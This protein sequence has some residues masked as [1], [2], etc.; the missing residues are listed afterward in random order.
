MVDLSFGGSAFPR[1]QEIREL[2][3]EKGDG[4]LPARF[5][6][7][8]RNEAF[9]RG[10]EYAH[11]TTDWGGYPANAQEAISTESIMPPGFVRPA[12]SEDTNHRL[13]RPTAPLRL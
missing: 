2:L 5:W 1:A 11:M 7:L 13:R 12:G 3:Y 6:E 8:D 10:L 9:Q 4:P